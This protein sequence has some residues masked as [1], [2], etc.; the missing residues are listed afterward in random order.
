M[1]VIHVQFP[2]TSAGN[3]A[4]REF[5]AREGFRPEYPDGST[6]GTIDWDAVVTA[7]DD[8]RCSDQARPAN[9]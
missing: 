2:L 4:A 3:K 1:V 9:G 5:L 6:V 8:Y 7:T